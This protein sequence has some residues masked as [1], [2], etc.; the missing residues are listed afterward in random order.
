MSF[1]DQYEDVL[2]LCYSDVEHWDYAT[3]MGYFDAY[4]LQRVSGGGGG[5]IFKEIPHGRLC[6]GLLSV[7]VRHCVAHRTLAAALGFRRCR[8]CNDV[9]SL[10][11]RT[12]ALIHWRAFPHARQCSNEFGTA[13]IG[14]KIFPP[15]TF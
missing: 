8:H 1:L 10:V 4:R 13:L 12:K 5:A 9:C 3:L 14:T 11:C 2:H 7:R 15:P 6:G